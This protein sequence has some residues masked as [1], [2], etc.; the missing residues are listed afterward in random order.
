MKNFFL[1]EVEST[2]Q[3]FDTS[4]RTEKPTD[5]LEI[6]EE[7]S[8]NSAMQNMKNLK[9]HCISINSSLK[10]KEFT[11]QIINESFAH[12]CDNFTYFFS[13]ESMKMI[14]T[15]K[16]T[17]TQLLKVYKNNSKDYHHFV[18]DIIVRLLESSA[19]TLEELIQIYEKNI[20]SFKYLT[21]K[22]VLLMLQQ[23][24]TPEELWQVYSYSSEYF[25][26]FLMLS[27]KA[28]SSESEEYQISPSILCKAFLTNKD[29]F[30]LF[31]SDMSLR[32]VNIYIKE[33]ELLALYQYMPND[34]SLF[35]SQNVINILKNGVSYLN[36]ITAYKIGKIQQFTSIESYNLLSFGKINVTDLLDILTN[37]PE[38]YDDFTSS[39]TI[40]L[41]ELLSNKEKLL[42][43]FHYDPKNYHIIISKPVLL[44]LN[45]GLSI[46]DLLESYIKSSSKKFYKWIK[47]QIN[48]YMQ[49]EKIQ[50]YKKSYK[51]FPK[52]LQKIIS[53][54]NY[55]TLRI[56]GYDDNHLSEM[57]NTS[58][59]FM[60]YFFS[61][62]ISKMINNRLI[63]NSQLLNIYKIDSSGFCYFISDI[64]IDIMKKYDD[65]NTARAVMIAAY[66]VNSFYFSDFTSI[67]TKI[68]LEHG[69]KLNELLGLYTKAPQDFANFTQNKTIMLLKAGMELD[70]LLTAYS[71]NS[72]NFH[73][74]CSQGSLD[75]IGLY[76]KPEDLLNAY[77]IHLGNFS[78][79]TSK[80][81]IALLQLG[82]NFNDLVKTSDIKKVL[83]LFTQYDL[84]QSRKTTIN[85]VMKRI[86]S[87]EFMR[88]LPITLSMSKTTKDA[89]CLLKA[90]NHNRDKYSLF[91]SEDS[92]KMISY[93]IPIEHLLS[94]YQKSVDYF[95]DFIGQDSQFIIEQKFC[96]SNILYKKFEQNPEHYNNINQKYIITKN[97][98]SKISEIFSSTK[99]KVSHIDRIA[100]TT[101]YCL[102]DVCR[103]DQEKAALFNGAHQF[104]RKFYKIAKREGLTKHTLSF[105]DDILE[106]INSFL[107]AV[108]LIA[109][110]NSVTRLCV[111][112][113][114][115]PLNL[116][117]FCHKIKHRSSDTEQ[118]LYKGNTRHNLFL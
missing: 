64:T 103:N 76:V 66:Q 97:L 47:D 75:L 40:K 16:I 33:D 29:Y 6:E 5:S 28:L 15:K 22:S 96:S 106:I 118:G 54:D 108:G 100:A 25:P 59:E 79:F 48:I 42:N 61:K 41:L 111:D 91:A 104:A 21:S 57:Y 55:I 3:F 9:E 23:E 107:E 87:N 14:H 7:K 26:Y 31:T 114:G 17:A 34:F 101:V 51:Y 99:S 32:M 35:T 72:E 50:M 45:K 39:G 56:L 117:G 88:C 53:C 10:T 13:K 86:H 80:D 92:K 85:E 69:I 105:C 65:I 24:M 62:N 112:L 20:L 12:D 116:N 67:N 37:N 110:T 46:D 30:S 68:L 81:S 83:Y 113:D 89:E 60:H 38:N 94:A 63:T 18:S 95:S 11:R 84:I 71:H 4:R 93:G 102:Y 8:S 43:A 1:S 74:F 19:V 27:S 90:F 82:I 2:S 70:T 58:T 115:K 77:K 52:D 109:K 73:L 44:I 36:L 49:D 98:C 78:V